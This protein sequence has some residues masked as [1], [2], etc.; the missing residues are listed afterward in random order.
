MKTIFILVVVFIGFVFA[1]S[2]PK[3]WRFED[4]YNRPSTVP[5]IRFKR[6]YYDFQSG[7]YIET[8]NS[9]P[10]RIGL[11]NDRSREQSNQYNYN[12]GDYSPER[13]NTGGYPAQSSFEESRDYGRL[14]TNNNQ[15]GKYDSGN[16]EYLSSY[17]P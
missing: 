10:E 14:N 15:M 13:Y 5:Q 16:R 6:G 12:R 7:R 3:N 1:R 8:T 4:P 11:T 9:S 2:Y 17:T